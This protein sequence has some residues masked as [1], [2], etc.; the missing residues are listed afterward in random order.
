[1]PKYD[2]GQRHV[3]VKFEHVAPLRHGFDEQKLLGQ[4]ELLYKE[5][6]QDPTVQVWFWFEH[7]LI[8]QLGSSVKNYFNL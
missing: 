5:Q 1:M 7:W 2:V 6:K 3:E 4:Y 8:S